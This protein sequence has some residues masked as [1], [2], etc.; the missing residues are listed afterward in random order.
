[1]S[2]GGWNQVKLKVGSGTYQT[3]TASITD[4]VKVTFNGYQSF[5]DVTSIVRA[6]RGGTYTIA[7][8]KCDTVNATA[9]PIVNAYGGWN[10]VVVYR[11]STQPLRNLTVFDGM[12]VVRDAAGFNSRDITVSG[13]RCPPTGNVNAKFGMVIYDGDRGAVDGFLM[14]QNATG[15]FTNQT[16]AGESAATTS[17]SSD[18]WNSS[19]TDTG[20]LV[21]TRMPAHQNTYGYDAHIYKLNNTGYKYLRNNDNTATIRIST[22]SE[23]YVLGLV[24]SE[25]DTY[26]PEMILENS[27]VNLNGPV[28]EKGD[29]LLITGTVKNNGTDGAVNV[30]ATDSLPPYFRYVPGSITYN[31]VA[32]TD[33]AGD[34]Q[35]YYNA[36]SRVVTI[37]VGS[38]SD[39]GNGGAVAPNGT[40]VYSFSYKLTVS[41]NCA[42]I[43]VTPLALLQRS[44]LSY[45][46]VV[47]AAAGAAGSRPVSSSGCIN[48]VAPDTVFLAN[49][50]EVVLPLRIIEFIGTGT[51][52]GNEIKW[53]T[54]ETHD[55]AFYELQRSDNG[56]DFYPVF[57]YAVQPR[58]GVFPARYTD[59]SGK[60]IGLAYYRLKITRLSGQHVLSAWVVI[61]RTGNQ[62]AEFSLSPNPVAYG[63]KVRVNSNRQFQ[64]I[65]VFDVNG[66]M[67]KSLSNPVSGSYISV[68]ELKP[69]LY[70]VKARAGDSITTVKL[71]VQ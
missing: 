19:I 58:S 30:S 18:A 5:A 36:T 28:L 70:F 53:I 7:N 22:A 48:P 41:D 10:L 6:N 39:A 27:L 31:S 66:K 59:T 45:L 54:E 8:V 52:A 16:S 57:S 32:L 38:G 43:G 61:S 12:A 29:T 60:Y 51:S 9:Q 1:M 55:V 37:N 47:S 3:I 33:A 35:A 4:T 67:V 17:G 64:Q 23:G 26:E 65:Q 46:G 40:A 49:G 44:S 14:R 34:D 42:D 56:R 2:A 62:A 25:I 69:G 15:T 24:T 13:F 21:N 71:I 50:C 20:A 11:D 63:Q 68:G